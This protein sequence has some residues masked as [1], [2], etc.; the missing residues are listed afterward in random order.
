[1]DF[2]RR[3]ASRRETDPGRAVAVLPS[4]FASET[5]LRVTY[6]QTRPAQDIDEDEIPLSP[7]AI[8]APAVTSELPRRNNGKATSPTREPGEPP[9]PDVA[10]PRVLH[11]RQGANSEQ[12]PPASPE[13]QELSLSLPATYGLE[14]VNAPSAIHALQD[15]AAPPSQTRLALPLSQAILT[16]RTLQSRDDNQVVHVT[17]GRIDVVANTAPAPAVRRSPTP[18]EA[19]VP[20]AEYL[21]GG[22]G[23]RR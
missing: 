2:L 18:R 23:G 7:G 8:S 11:G 13:Q 20:L 17:I 12:A 16:Q 6:G 9:D 1:M 10:E 19:T 22:N 3:L 5:P 21:R 14:A 15:V 4:R